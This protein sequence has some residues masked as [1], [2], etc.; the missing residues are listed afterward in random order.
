VADDDALEAIRRK[1]TADRTRP[2]RAMWIVALLIGTVCTIGFVVMFLVEPSGSASTP[3]R[4]TEHGGLGFTAGLLFGLVIG[5]ALGF[6]IARQRQSA[7]NT[8]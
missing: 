6:A 1:A 5:V 4:S 3:Q 2:S 8:P 7:R